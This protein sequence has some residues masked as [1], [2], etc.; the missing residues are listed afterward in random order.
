MGT[1]GLS[2]PE[3]AAAG[4]EMLGVSLLDPIVEAATT[5]GARPSVRALLGWQGLLFA[6]AGSE[7]IFGLNAKP[8]GHGRLLRV[9]A[10]GLIYQAP[11]DGRRH[12]LT[13]ESA[14][15]ALAAVEPDIWLPLFPIGPL[16]KR[17]A[18]QPAEL[19]YS[20]AERAIRAT[21]ASDVVVIGLGQPGEDFPAALAAVRTLGALGFALGTGGVSDIEGRAHN[22]APEL[23]RVGPVTAD[24]G[25]AL[26]HLR[27]GV[28]VA[29]WDPRPG[30]LAG[31]VLAPEGIIDLR[32]ADR[33]RDSRPIAQHCGCAACGF[34][35][36]YLHHLFQANE[37]L[38]P[39]LAALHN[40]TELLDRV[41]QLG[42]ESG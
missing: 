24:P 35:R 40:T 27:R 12:A 29:R 36:A 7:T 16:S 34:S 19:A 17:L 30:A 9:E 21:S 13:P 22:L 14:A 37:L 28:D 39:R 20:W 8:R 15:N 23:L 6:D 3:L 42:S 25:E 11:R 2:A 31:R 18:I 26:A 5:E 38:G 4:A 41:R 10:N 32:A 1:G 33:E